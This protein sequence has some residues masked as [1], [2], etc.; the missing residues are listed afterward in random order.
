MASFI[1]G[2]VY[3]AGGGSYINMMVA[4]V[5]VTMIAGVVAT[6]VPIGKRAEVVALQGSDVPRCAFSL[7]V[8][9]MHG[10][11]T[12]VRV[13]Q[14]LNYGVVVDSKHIRPSSG[15]RVTSTY[16]SGYGQSQA[17]W[18]ARTDQ[19]GVNRSTNKT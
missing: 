2:Y 5:T 11:L 17:N 19:S 3:D 12:C 1:G 18:L 16:V 7:L 10:F 14:G 4:F 6:R 9:C 15:Q 8:V 13:V